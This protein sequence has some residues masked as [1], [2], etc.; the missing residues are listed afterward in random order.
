MCTGGHPLSEGYNIVRVTKGAR[1]GSSLSVGLGGLRG[2][3]GDKLVLSPGQRPVDQS[4]GRL[5]LAGGS[6]PG[7]SSTGDLGN[8]EGQAQLQ[9]GLGRIQTAPFC[10]VNSGTTLSRCPLG[11]TFQ[12]PVARTPGRA[13]H[14]RHPCPGSPQ[15]TAAKGADRHRFQT[16]GPGPPLHSAAR[17]REFA[18]MRE[19]LV[20]PQ[21]PP[22]TQI[23]SFASVTSCKE[24]T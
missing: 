17:T 4:R 21:S 2:F 24:R 19:D 14:S 9:S 15:P 13:L 20:F 22:I 3:A 5:G 18:G 6:L 11:V 16:P 1:S 8:R 10:T 12:W 7:P 23:L